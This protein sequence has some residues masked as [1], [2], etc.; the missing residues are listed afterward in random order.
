MIQ[1]RK[2]ST[3]LSGADFTSY[4]QGLIDISN[5]TSVAFDDLAESM[6]SALS[7]GVEQEK[8]L[9]FVENSVK[10]SKGGFTQTATAIDKRYRLPKIK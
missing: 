8:V 6:Y 10:L 5:R 1:Y 2:A 7:A 9:E 4:Y 3:L